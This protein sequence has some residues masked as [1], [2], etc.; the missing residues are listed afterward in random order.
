MLIK[1]KVGSIFIMPQYDLDPNGNVTDS[2]GWS[3]SIWLVFAADTTMLGHSHVWLFGSTPD[4]TY[5]SF[6]RIYAISYLDNGDFDLLRDIRD[7]SE[8]LWMRMPMQSQVD[9]LASFDTTV[10]FDSGDVLH[11]VETFKTTYDGVSDVSIAGT[12]FQ[13][14][15]FS[16]KTEGT[17]TSEQSPTVADVHG[18]ETWLFIPRLGFFGKREL[19]QSGHSLDGEPHFDGER[20]VLKRYQLK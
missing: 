16:V 6:D 3:D 5:H 14:I 2:F 8:E 11:I 9:Q 17:A 15:A 1:P 12:S 13:A 10:E 20:M 7:P 19:M 18:V 4:T